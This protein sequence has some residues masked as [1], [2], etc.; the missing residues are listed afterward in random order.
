[1]N[2]KIIL[3]P[4]KTNKN[5]H[6]TWNPDWIKNYESPWSVFEKY[7][8]A[9][10]IF[11][12]D[13]LTTFGTDELNAL[14]HLSLTKI[15]TN[16]ENMDRI[17]TDKINQ[18]LLK[19]VKEIS[20][21]NIKLLKERLPQKNLFREELTYCKICLHKG[22]H[23]IFHQLN[24]INNC[25]FHPHAKLYKG[26][27]KCYKRILYSINDDICLYRCKCGYE[28]VKNTK[29][30]LKK[31]VTHKPEIVSPAILR[32]LKLNEN[33][34]DLLK[35]VIFIQPNVLEVQNDL[36]NICLSQVDTTF[37][38]DSNCKQT[39]YYSNK[40]IAGKTQKNY[41]KSI[42]KND[43][44]G[45][46]FFNERIDEEIYEQ[47]EKTYS[48]LAAR[49]RRTVLKDHIRCLKKIFKEKETC[50]YAYA[51]LN[52]RVCIEGLMKH[53]DVIKPHYK[54]YR[55]NHTGLLSAAHQ[56]YFRGVRIYKNKKEN[57]LDIERTK[58]AINHLFYHILLKHFYNW[59]EFAAKKKY[60]IDG[61]VYYY[62]YSPFVDEPLPFVMI[63]NKKNRTEV[64][65]WENIKSKHKQCHCPYKNLKNDKE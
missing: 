51:Y 3:L 8:Y 38:D 34:I 40:L 53:S 35:N 31:W 55:K 7:K 28:F 44:W 10:S 49:L 57:V 33:E 9:N 41:E 59:L 14:K 63:R 65:V 23:S 52:W 29:S 19:P 11:S 20:Q 1:M 6:Y 56:E 62:Y 61:K 60:M 21:Q 26:C 13:F 42:K 24:V 48:S 47:T 58:W 18:I 46:M 45:S 50:P 27:P 15:N 64:H 5:T 12:K 17:C 4:D 39:V 30:M 2:S 25:P 54:T 37:M 36:L 32:L 43:Y 22:Y 16:L